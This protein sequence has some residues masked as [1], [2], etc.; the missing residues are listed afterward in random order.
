MPETDELKKAY[1]TGN[2]MHGMFVQGDILLLTSIPYRML[3]CGDIV[4]CFDNSPFYVHRII[5]KTPECAVTMGDNNARPDPAELTPQSDFMLVTAYIP[6]HSPGR[7]L[8]V[9]RGARGM[10]RFRR[11]QRLVRGRMAVERLFR[12][13]R[14]LGVLRL[15]A[16]GKTRFRDGT[17]QWSFMG[18]PVAARTPDGKT[19]Y[20]HWSKRL[21]FRIP[22]HTP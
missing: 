6:L 2:S 18:I 14:V 22:T 3:E 10:T 5:R 13:F 15:P 17:V 7:V 11:Q 16:H 8:P 21:F 4:A 12:L 9:E 20:L 1:Y 19:T